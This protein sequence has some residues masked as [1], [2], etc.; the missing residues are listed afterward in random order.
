MKHESKSNHTPLRLC[1]FTYIF[2]QHVED[3]LVLNRANHDAYYSIKNVSTLMKFFKA[4][5]STALM[6]RIF[7]FIHD[8]IN[9]IKCKKK[10]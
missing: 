8:Q 3:E 7:L 1:C 10:V 5:F 2:Q 4:K 6:E 9:W